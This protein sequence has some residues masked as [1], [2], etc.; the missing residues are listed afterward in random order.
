MNTTSL[1]TF[2]SEGRRTSPPVGPEAESSRSKV[3]ESITSGTLP[4]PYSAMFSTG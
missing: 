1:G 3:R 2:P 4:A